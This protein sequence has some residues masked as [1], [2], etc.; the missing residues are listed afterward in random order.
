MPVGLVWTQCSG[1]KFEAWNLWL[2]IKAGASGWRRW[3]SCTH[4]AA[5]LP[6]FEQRR[7]PEQAVVLTADPPA[8]HHPACTAYSRLPL[9]GYFLIGYFVLCSLSMPGLLCCFP[10]AGGCADGAALGDSAATAAVPEGVSG[11]GSAAGEG[12][13]QGGHPRR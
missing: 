7:A 3:G 11:M 1:C 5:L 12:H 9:I 6:A 10:H 2:E 8:M 4:P 13:C